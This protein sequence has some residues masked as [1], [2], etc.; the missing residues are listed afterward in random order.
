MNPLEIIQ[1]YY[2]QDTKLYY[3][4]VEHSKSVAKKA[5]EIAH[6]VSYLNPD[7]IF[8]QE[9]AM[10]HDI[11]IYLTYAPKIECYGNRPYVEH[12]FLGRQILEKEGL[13]KHALVC[14]THVGTGLTVED[15]RF[16]N[17]QLP[18]RN[19]EPKTLEEEIICFADKFFSKNE[20]YLVN[21]KSIDKI[22][23]GLLKH[24]KKNLDMFNIWMKK[25]YS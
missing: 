18:L 22:K 24:G 12:G 1:K 11:G 21:E 23:K 3:L 15:I 4:L 17:L 20:K 6:R 19:M 10:L 5:I 13:Y 7:F 2:S 9:A 8:I 14:E 25:F 16:Q